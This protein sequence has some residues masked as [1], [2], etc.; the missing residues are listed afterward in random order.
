M[1]RAAALGDLRGRAAG[2]DLRRRV[3]PAPG[4]KSQQLV[5]ARDHLAV[6]LDDQQRVAQVAKLV[7]R[8]QQPRVVARVQAD[9]RFVE[10]VQHAAQA[11]AELAGQPNPL[12]F[13][14]GQ[15]RGAAGQR[16]VLEAHVE[17]ELQRGR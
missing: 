13:A 8:R 5:A 2:D 15:R 1:T 6:V 17:Q 12:R 14:V 11:A 16:Q 10:D 3:V 9:R 7:Q 4:P